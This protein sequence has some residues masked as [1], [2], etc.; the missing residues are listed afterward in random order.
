M[1]L[2]VNPCFMSSVLRQVDCT[3]LQKP[4]LVAIILFSF[5][6][7]KQKITGWQLLMISSDIDRHRPLYWPFP[8]RPYW[9]KITGFILLFQLC[10]WAD[11]HSSSPLTLLD[12]NG[13]R[14][15]LVSPV[16]P[17]FTCLP[18]VWRIDIISWWNFW[19][20]TVAF[21]VLGFPSQK[22]LCLSTICYVLI[23]TVQSLWVPDHFPIVWSNSTFTIFTSTSTSCLPQPPLP[24]SIRSH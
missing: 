11:K 3:C 15:S 23:F 13:M 18:V 19:F 22:D 12:L 14:P 1:L 9:Y 5:C 16:T 20:T 24:P 8:H 10:Q 4:Q 2:V 21:S 6:S 7:Q 17:V